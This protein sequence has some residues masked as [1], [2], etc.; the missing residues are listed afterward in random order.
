[1]EQ[2][3]AGSFMLSS[4]IDLFR[5][6]KIAYQGYFSFLKNDLRIYIGLFFIVLG[7]AVTNTLMIWLFGKPFNFLVAQDFNALASV[8]LVLI[9]VIAINQL[10][11]FFAAYGASVLGLRFVGILRTAILEKILFLPY[12]KRNE[13]PK[14]DLLSRLSYDID[15]I[16][17]IMV[18]T[19]LY[20]SSHIFTAVFYCV[21][22]FYIDFYLAFVALLLTP[23]F[24]FHQKLFAKKKR[25]A[26]KR[27]FDAN[28]ALLANEDESL[29]NAVVI[30]AFNAQSKILQ[31]HKS[32]FKNAFNWAVRERYL[33]NSFF[34]S[35][36][37][38]VYFCGL[39][40]V[41]L[42]VERFQSD[43]I[44]I[45]HLV[46]FLLYMGYMSVPIRGVVELFFQ[47]QSDLMASDRIQSILQQE[48]NVKVLPAISVKKGDIVFSGVGLTRGDKK[49]FSNLNIKLEA[50]KSYGLVG[51]SGVGKST[52][53]YLLMKNL[54]PDSG[55]ILIDGQDISQISTES[56]LDQITMIWQLPFIFNLSIKE[57]L[58]LAKNDSSDEKLEEVCEKSGALDYINKLPD[59]FDTIIGSQGV[60]LS[61]GQIQK[62]NI[63]QAL[64]R[65]SKIL[66]LDE[67]S[68][69]L[70]SQSEEQLIATLKSIRQDKTTIFITHRYSAIQYVDLVIYMDSNFNVTTGSHEK[71]Y[72]ENA[73][74]RHA[75]E[76]QQGQM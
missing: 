3:C 44:T 10:C 51:P 58:L 55:A 60:N 54:H 1:L 19:P 73:A 75:L 2:G 9:I 7:V 47:S 69:A 39:L 59:K 61:V 45:A 65:D 14:G 29:T 37:F 71:L 11:H 72:Q 20:L 62:L 26:A 28:G 43:E 31:Q 42:G 16:Q 17:R 21:M 36:S 27:F 15:K 18:E 64:L 49:I 48:K 52:L 74:Y 68:S 76:W 34:A 33:D 25:F 56:L 35:L 23:L 66:I 5:Q 40:I 41:Y 67:A 50:G 46:S 30:S 6:V 57:N 8:L 63:A 22:L 38:I 4:Q 70:D 13:I 24:Y 12:E 32:R 53:A